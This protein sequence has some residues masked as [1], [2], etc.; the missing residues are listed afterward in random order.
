MLFS[1]MSLAGK[2]FMKNSSF[3][4]GL[5]VVQFGSQF[6]NLLFDNADI[7][8]KTMQAKK[9]NSPEIVDSETMR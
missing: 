9:I 5:V 4:E 6:Y 2:I 3:T 1:G 7:R 8:N